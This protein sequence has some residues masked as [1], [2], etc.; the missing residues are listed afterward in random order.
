MKRLYITLI[1]VLIGILLAK[2]VSAQNEDIRWRQAANIKSPGMFPSAMDFEVKGI[3]L[4]G[5]PALMSVNRDEPNAPSYFKDI[6]ARPTLDR[7]YD[8]PAGFFKIHYTTT[9]E[10]AVD[11]LDMDPVDGVPDY[12]N[13]LGLLADFVW[14]E[15]I[16][17]VGFDRPPDDGWYTPN[18]G[19]SKYDLYIIN[20]A[21]NIYGYTE[22]ER[23]VPGEDSVYTSFIALDNDYSFA[24]N[25]IDAIKVTMAHEFFH[26]IAFGYDASEY[27]GSPGGSRFSVWWYEV[28]SVWL[29]EVIFDD[30]NDY[31]Q[32]M[33]YFY[34]YPNISLE[35]DGALGT[36]RSIHKYAS[37]VWAFYLSER[38]G[39]EIIKSIWEGCG[40]SP[41]YN[42]LTSMDESIL[43]ASRGELDL[44]TAFAEFAAWNY[45][46]GSRANESYG[47]SEA[48][49]WT[50][51]PD[52]VMANITSYPDTVLFGNEIPAGPEFLAANYIDFKVP[53]ITSGG[54]LAAFNGEDRF[55]WEVV[56]F[57]HH[58]Q[59]TI[60]APEIQ[61]LDLNTV[62]KT[63]TIGVRN[64]FTFTDVI[65]IPCP[66]GIDS[67][68]DSA[69]YAYHYQV[70]DSLIGEESLPTEV[71]L[72]QNYPNPFVVTGGG[73]LTNIPFEIHQ[74]ARPEV[75][76]YTVSGELVRNL[77]LP[78]FGKIP[79]GFYNSQFQWDGRNNE[80][81]LVAGGIYI[82]HIY[83]EIGSDI[84]KLILIR[85][86]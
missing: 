82:Y 52:S 13:N 50:K 64:W 4:S 81:E 29:E 30:I 11:P 71:K 73:E 39:P 34:R 61:H 44:N 25:A 24:P 85:E 49:L 51:I 63:D 21:Q 76:I 14:R 42:L 69:Q 56:I 7:E 48:S 70:E 79:A 80:G 27:L 8:S 43:N 35:A 46:T 23:N 16:D 84:K 67:H 5:T 26:A 58:I 59:N 62:S 17:S 75:R 1:T 12:I 74:I 55:A 22:R 18:G 60:T 19:D 28:C 47:Y 3:R 20:Q 31:L 66:V 65:M 57:G 41:G 36:V 9:G 83:S 40:N 78:G 2:P 6:Q 45:F 33:P 77:E 72:Y 86:E 15:S 53:E 38:L 10:N 68:R 37:C 32:Y 54:L